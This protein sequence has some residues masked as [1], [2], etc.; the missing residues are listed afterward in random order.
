MV[1]GRSRFFIDPGALWHVVVGGHILSRGELPHADGF[2]HTF[3]GRPWIAQQWLGEC[4]LA[5][6]HRL[7]GLD[8]I[9][10]ATATLLAGLC[11]W[12]GHRLLRVGMH[13]L[14]AALVVA[15]AVLGSAY[16]VHPR[17]HLVNLVLLGWTFARLCDF[18]AGRA[19]L[20]SLFWLAPLY[21]LWANVHG[22]MVGGVATLAAAAAGWGV[23][24][25]LGRDTPLAG[26]RQLI[27]F[28]AL[29]LACGL[30]AFLNPYGAE[31]P[32]V[33]FAL[34]G[35][36][37]L[38]RVIQEHSPLLAAGPVAWTVVL[39]GLVYLA[40][41]LGVSPRQV[42]VT[43]LLPLLW[44]ALAWTRIRHGP[45]FVITAALALG[46]MYPHVRWREWLARRG[47]VTCRLRPAG[48]TTWRP[49][50]LPTLLVL[51]ALVL[52]MAGIPAPLVGRGWAHLPAD[53]SPVE[54]LPEL[55]AYEKASPPGGPSSTTCCLPGSSSIAPPTCGCSSM[56]AANST[57]TAGWSSTRKPIRATPSGSRTGPG[58]TASTA[59]W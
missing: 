16:H 33:W 56:T 7:G 43:W 10:L 26:Y 48:P 27:P 18:E 59:P 39:F 47:S 52:H 19:S 23:A 36:P 44:F 46:E 1:A 11:A 25:L 32:R 55:Q 21:V 17:P 20:R 8:T 22:G 38:P 51:A 9:L 58:S 3:A 31:L 5:F 34:M 41:L 24:K 29:V 6:F 13:P 53:T 54:L 14:I 45:L 28:G 37:V 35:S 57:A 4:A 42:R 30:A 50:F 2:S 49:A 15:L 40:A 12:L